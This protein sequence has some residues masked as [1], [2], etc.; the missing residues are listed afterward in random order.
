MGSLVSGEAPAILEA[1]LA[2]GTGRVDLSVAVRNPAVSAALERVSP[3][4]ARRLLGRWRRRE[5]GLA[6]VPALWLEI[7]LPGAPPTDPTDPT[8]PID[9]IDPTDLENPTLPEPVLCARLPSGCGEGWLRDELYPSLQGEA[10]SPRQR[11]LLARLLRSLP[12]PCAP[13]Y[14]FGLSARGRPAARLEIFAPAFP[15]LER[16]AAAIR[17]A[18]PA[19]TPDLAPALP[20]FAGGERLHLSLDL[21]FAAGEGAPP[22]AGIE[23][24]FP[25]QPSREPRWG[26]LFDRLVEAG[27]CD[28][29]RRE[30]AL[31]WPGQDT[32]W[33]APGSWP[34]GAEGGRRISVRGLSHVKVVCGGE[35][36]AEAKVYLTLGS[37]ERGAPGAAASSATSASDRST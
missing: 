5:G 8:D 31:A 19:A 3:P 17:R 10:L 33:T 11:E 25:R 4:A 15:D 22:R 13:L 29:G 18:A 21:P 37:V 2:G 6:A 32:F 20:L 34:L 12:P 30:A 26:A 35:G 28:P 23:G 16:L 1:R 7:D 24:S 36:G 14:A 27:L 9:P